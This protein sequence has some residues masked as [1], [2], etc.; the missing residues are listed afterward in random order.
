MVSDGVEDDGQLLGHQEGVDILARGG[1]VSVSNVLTCSQ[2]KRKKKVRNMHFI[3]SWK[4][5]RKDNYYKFN[6]TM[7][8]FLN[9]L[10]SPSSG[11][12]AGVS[13]G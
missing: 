8:G 11:S 3:A 5:K 4:L 1:T 13:P 12:D 7:I 10:P 6:D 2:N 9:L